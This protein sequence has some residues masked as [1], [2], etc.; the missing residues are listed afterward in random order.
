[1]AEVLVSFDAPIA[2]ELGVFHARAVGRKAED[3]MWEG[4][5]EFVDESGEVLVTPAESRQPER[6]HLVYWATGLTPVYL[7]GALRRARNPLEVRVPLAEEPASESPAPQVTVRTYVRHGPEPV[8]NPFE[9]G[10]RSLHILR[11]E[12]SAFNRPRLQ[13]IIAAFELNPG[14][15]DLGWM[16]DAQLVHFIVTAVEAQLK[17]RAGSASS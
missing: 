7:E 3:G 1:M 6:E 4:W 12:L 11:Q 8:L 16:S 2:D 10:S 15:E 9:V 5:L 17:T 13:N 14:G